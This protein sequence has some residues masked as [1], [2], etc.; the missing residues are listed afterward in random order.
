VYRLWDF[1]SERGENQILRW[2]RRQRLT[3]RD[4]AL[5]NQKLDRLV[6]IDFDLA[7]STK[8]LAGPI[9]GNIYKLII[10]GDV[11]LRPL[12]CRGP[13]EL[14]GEYTLLLG[15]VERDWELA[16]A[17]AVATAAAN[18]AVVMANPR[19]RR[20]SHVRIPGRP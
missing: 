10:H 20:C 19:D 3:V 1:Q 8:L 14:E 18:R 16:P 15:A 12:L 7:I 5:L 13:I 17:N 2:V 11:M 9:R 6:Q 4:R